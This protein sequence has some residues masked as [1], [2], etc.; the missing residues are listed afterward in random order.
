M[1]KLNAII[2][3]EWKTFLGSERGVFAVYGVLILSWSF[4]PL[5][6]GLAGT[7]IEDIWWLFFSVVISGTF[8][9]TVFVSERLGGSMEILLTSGF[10][11]NA[12]LFGKT[13]FIIGMSIAIGGIC[14]AFSRLWLFLSEQGGSGL[15]RAFFYGAGLYCAGTCMNAACGAWMS[16]RLQSPR[17]IPIVTILVMSLIVAGFS[18]LLYFVNVPQWLFPVILLSAAF[19]FYV[20]AK[21]GFNGEKIVQP[22]NL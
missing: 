22:I 5:Y 19:V 16:V 15:D 4:L 14:L 12:V 6:K 9:N 20:L 3:K 11:R 1:K 13:V 7:G 17:L 10:T 8:S 18:V 21:K 2:S